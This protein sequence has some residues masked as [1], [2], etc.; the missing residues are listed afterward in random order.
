MLAPCAPLYML[1]GS[2]LVVLQ[3]DL[4]HAHASVLHAEPYLS[5]LDCRRGLVTQLGLT[6]WQYCCEIFSQYL[7]LLFG[8]APV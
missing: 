2:R 8:S 7:L 1:L 5:L 6:V 4:T 3:P